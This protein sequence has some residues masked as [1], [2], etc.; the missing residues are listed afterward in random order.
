MSIEPES[1]TV[2]VTGG[3][4]YVAGWMI[5]GLLRRGY[6]VR[7]TLRSLGREEKVRAAIARQG[8]A[9]DRL[10]FVTADLLS[11][12]DWDEAV[13]DC[14]TVFHVASPMGQ[15]EPKA[16]LVRP[17]REGTERVLKAASRHQVRRFVY[18]SS[19]VAAQAPS[20][21]GELQPR[22]DETTW[23]NAQQKGLGE[24][25]R[26]KTLAERMAWD[27]IQKDSSGMTLATI[28]PGMILGPVMADGVSGS[29]EVIYRLLKGKVPA[30][31]H[32]GF[33]ITDVQDL[34]DLNIRAMT[35]PEAADQR[36]LGVG[37][38]LWMSEIAATLRE[39]LGSNASAVTTRALPDFVLRLAAVFQQEA[40]FM[41]PMLGK[42]REF[43]VSK[44]AA[45][46]D[47]RPR[48]SK[49][50]VIDC[51]ESMQRNGLV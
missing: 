6:T 8:C 19:V 15:G 21:P 33:A 48:P 1:T 43:D 51:A 38:F 3:S 22:T 28:L 42:R 49:Q 30:I 41:A 9:D 14:D 35:N 27:F 18:T 4:G 39:H 13:A 46:L 29:L 50:T 26:S 32:I 2:L 24:Y 37:D 36:F 44:A 23:T 12:V 16:D 40:R 20:I 45:L 17:A 25:A 34:V 7:A 47:W 10:A 11:D 31:P 5:V